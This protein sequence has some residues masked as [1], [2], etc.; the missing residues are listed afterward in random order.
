M[1]K[2]LTAL[3]LA[4]LMIFGLVPAEAFAAGSTPEQ[5]F[6]DVDSGKYYF[7][8]V[9]WAL[10]NHITVGTSKTTFSPEKT[11]TRCQIVTFLYRWKGCPGYSVKSNFR[12]VTSDKYY[13]DAVSWALENNIT[14]GISEDTFGPDEGCSRAQAVTF[15]WRAAGCPGVASES[16]FTDV[17]GT[18]YYAPAV[19]WAVKGGITAGTASDRFSPN[20]TC[21]RSQIVTF[22]YRANSVENSSSSGH[23]ENPRGSVSSNTTPAAIETPALEP[24]ETPA[25]TP[26][27]KDTSPAITREEWIYELADAMV[28][29]A[30]TSTPTFDDHSDV[31]KADLVQAALEN[32]W[33]MLKPDSENIVRFQPKETATREF[34]ASTA[35]KALNLAV[36][37]DSDPTYADVADLAYPKEDQRAVRIGIF[38]IENNKF[39]PEGAAHEQEAAHAIS[40]VKAILDKAEIKGTKNEVVYK[41]GVKQITD[42]TLVI[43]GEHKTIQIRKRNASRLHE[44]DIAVIH[45]P[46]NPADDAAI[47]VVSVTADARDKATV[48]FEAPELNDVIDSFDVEGSTT[49]E[50]KFIP[51]DGVKVVD[52]ASDRNTTSDSTI[53]DIVGDSENGTFDL[54]EKLSLEAA[55]PLNKKGTSKADVNV[56]LNVDRIDYRFVTEKKFGFTIPKE[57]YLCALGKATCSV[58]GKKEKGGDSRP[59]PSPTPTPGTGI[60]PVSGTDVAFPTLAEDDTLEKELGYVECPTP[61]GFTI[62]GHVYFV[63]KFSGSMKL[64][65]SI[66][67]KLGIQCDLA[68]GYRGI[69]QTSDPKITQ[70]YAQGE[71]S[72]GVRCSGTVNLLHFIKIIDVGDEVGFKGQVKFNLVSGI[73]FQWCAS[74]NAFLYD[75][76]EG[77]LGGD[78]IEEILHLINDKLTLKCKWVLYDENNSPV[79]ASLHYEETGKVPRC[80]RGNSAYNCEVQDEDG[81]PIYN[82]KIIVK[83]SDGNTVDTKY[84]DKDG[85]ISGMD[86]N[87]GYYTYSV[88]HEGYV[89]IS[90]QR[91]FIIGGAPAQFGPVR[92]H[93]TGDVSPVRTLEGRVKDATTEMP[94]RDAIVQLFSAK[95]SSVGDLVDSTVTDK[96]GSFSLNS[97]EGHYKLVV[98]ADGFTRYTMDVYNSSA[99][100]LVAVNMSPKSD[101]SKDGKDDKGDSDDESDCSVNFDDLKELRIVLSWGAEPLDLDAHLNIPIDK[102]R[103]QIYFGN[104]T[105]DEANLESDESSGYG[106]ES[107]IVKTV[108]DGVTQYF[109]N[110]FTNGHDSEDTK[111]AA[112]G[113][114][115]DIYVNDK[116]LTTIEVPKDGVGN[117]WHVFDI[118]TRTNSFILKNTFGS[119]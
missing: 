115:V 112:S 4:V 31:E 97:E 102:G 78:T 46:A 18:A 94:I 42:P 24:T 83:S 38:Q 119:M 49:S 66:K 109:V 58:E 57:A 60:V 77:Q 33:F 43:D 110:D 118:D 114:R 63:Y 88:S 5:S 64:E 37:G 85:R 106:P 68:S 1:R 69:C 107:I 101:S 73:P 92:L 81:K 103:K 22:L 113:A 108:N 8:P 48:A 80:T 2:K 117:C 51:A 55:I 35:V 89:S 34:V 47:K 50:A 10:D 62:G 86:L 41:K 100:G 21:T 56:A 116:L 87:H 13:Y 98:S 45:N 53:E 19:N 76:F 28:L 99:L 67:V 29:K 82:A 27:P 111:L 93:R 61:G 52:K 15:L 40:I 3:I 72:G 36:N 105:E 96:N 30:S 74:L 11:C 16:R 75:Q 95:T 54:F 79:R 14:E 84:T 39:N 9:Y 23:T 71:I 26:T 104:R 59:K 65:C 32:G 91:L 25:P 7:K 44:G 70:L 17:T 20:E 12:D 90:N 6:E